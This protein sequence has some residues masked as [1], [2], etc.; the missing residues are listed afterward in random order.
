M[1]KTNKLYTPEELRKMF[2]YE[3]GYNVGYIE[4]DNIVAGTYRSYYKIGKKNGKFHEKGG[5]PLFDTV[6]WFVEVEE[7]KFKETSDPYKK[8]SA[9]KQESNNVSKR[10][11]L[12]SLIESAVISAI[13]DVISEEY[14]EKE[15]KVNYFNAGYIDAKMNCLGQSD[16]KADM[17]YYSTI[18]SE[19]KEYYTAGFERG[20]KDFEKKM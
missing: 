18:P 1:A 11:K 12:S 6:K 20:M 10:N 4:I 17:D 7:G 16:T 3:Q 14:T 19:Y 5:F 8:K 13:A 9:V 15:K 2:P